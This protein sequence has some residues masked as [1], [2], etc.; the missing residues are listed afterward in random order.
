[1][2][3]VKEFW[4]YDQAY[5]WTF[6]GN[7]FPDPALLKPVLLQYREQLKKSQRFVIDNDFLKLMYLTSLNLDKIEKWSNLSRL[8]YPLVWIEFD[9]H[10]KI[11]L[12][13]ET[14]TITRKGL[15]SLDLN[16][17][18]FR[19]G[20][21]L[22]ETNE[23]TGAWHMEQ[24]VGMTPNELKSGKVTTMPFL[25]SFGF[26]PEN[27]IIRKDMD[28]FT[29]TQI[30][31]GL[32][33]ECN[34]NRL[35]SKIN[36]GLATFFKVL[37]DNPKVSEDFRK[38]IQKNTLNVLNEEAGILRYVLVILAMLSEAPNVKE[39]VKPKEG[40]RY[41]GMNKLP[42]FGHTLVSL[43]LPKKKP[44]RYTMRLLDKASDNA[45]KLRAH[46]VRGHF[47][48]IERGKPLPYPCKH[49]PV[50]VENGLGMCKKCERMIRWVPSHTRGDS[51]LGW[52]YHDYRIES[53]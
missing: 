34:D 25:H 11:R 41:K 20:V 1:M 26:S 36:P 47:R 4:V 2:K 48:Q 44:V 40:F 19:T 22:R 21:L 42:Y 7:A 16:N 30:N 49:E 9:I 6:D 38:D 51:S 35:I 53:S 13:I 39:P 45:R 3:K 32:G 28:S 23:E 18:P 10:E 14:K 43:K 24:F 31:L 27:M 17:V 15:E 37:H 12:S 52:V 8:P 46:T 29:K 50:M 33:Y 5:S